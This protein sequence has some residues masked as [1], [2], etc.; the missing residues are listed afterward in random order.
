MGV[1]FAGTQSRILGNLTPAG[2]VHLIE[3]GI[4]YK[5]FL[6]NLADYQKTN[7]HVDVVPPHFVDERNNRVRSSRFATRQEE[8]TLKD[9]QE[10]LWMYDGAGYRELPKKSVHWEN[11][12]WVPARI[13]KTTRPV[14]AFDVKDVQLPTFSVTSSGDQAI[15]TANG[16]EHAVGDSEQGK[17]EL[18]VQELKISVVESLT[19]KGNPK[20]TDVPVSGS[21]EL[22]IRNYGRLELHEQNN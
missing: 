4:D 10:L 13:D 7:F 20:W 14:E 21:P 9:G 5:S 11:S 19:D 16:T 8:K 2:T 15:I 6:P 22:I 12:G 18:P 1:G 3:T 17:I